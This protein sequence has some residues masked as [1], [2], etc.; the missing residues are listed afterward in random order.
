MKTI[1]HH[2]ARGPEETVH[3]LSPVV[4]GRI[5]EW[6]AGNEP[7]NVLSV[8]RRAGR[9]PRQTG[10][11]RTP[12]IPSHGEWTSARRRTPNQPNRCDCRLPSTNFPGTSR[13]TSS[14]RKALI[15]LALWEH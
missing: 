13:K 15:S 9:R 7:A 8:R 2:D 12:A 4:S 1:E 3:H 10:V 6:E 11:I 14:A 5:R